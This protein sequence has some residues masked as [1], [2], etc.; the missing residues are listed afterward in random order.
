[1]LLNFLFPSFL[2]PRISSCLRLIDEV[3][4]LG[5]ADDVDVEDETAEE[6]EEEEASEQ[7]AR[8]REQGKARGTHLESEM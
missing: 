8:H 1:M 5:Q 4:V 3:F 2:S 6:D 7:D